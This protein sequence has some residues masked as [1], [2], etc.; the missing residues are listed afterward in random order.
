MLALVFGSAAWIWPHVALADPAAAQPC[1]REGALT[2]GCAAA[3]AATTDPKARSRLLFA[4]AYLEDEQEKYDAAIADLDQ[5]VALDPTNASAFHERAFARS[6]MMRFTEALQDLE[7]EGRLSPGEP[8]VYQERAFSQFHLGQLQAAYDSWD[9]VVRLRPGAVEALEARGDAA[10]WIGRFDRAN[11]DWSA[12]LDI[13]KARGDEQQIATAR[14]G[15]ARI[16]LWSTTSGGRNPEANCA[17]SDRDGAFG[18]P[19]L[20]GDCTRAFLK[21]RSNRERADALTIRSIA[22]MVG[23]QDETAQAPDLEVAAALD[24]DNEQRHANL[25]GAYVSLHHAWAARQEF[26]RAIAMKRSFYALAGRASARYNLK[27]FDG[28]FADAKASYELQPNDVALMVLG[29][30]AL[31]RLKDPKAAKLYWMGA[32][33]LGGRDDSLIARL[34]SVGVEDP[35]KE[36][37][38]PAAN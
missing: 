38:D 37:A 15:L 7:V 9:Q 26:D 33:H 4:R 14:K 6:T 20:I 36:P 21:A 12:A 35:A 31:E 1:D 23:Q 2:A 22:W 3:I 25:G 10:L 34:K 13:V 17:G 11:A 28:A 32:Y 29:D 8:N 19:Y 30:L 5:A 18:A 27:D 16:A 24:P